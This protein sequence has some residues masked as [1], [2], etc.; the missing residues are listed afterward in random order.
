MS[1]LISI[2]A[3]LLAGLIYGLVVYLL[4]KKNG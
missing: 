1:Y 4:N 3:G 2:S